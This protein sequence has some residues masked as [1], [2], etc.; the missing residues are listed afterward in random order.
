[1]TGFVY[2]EYKQN[3][4]LLISTAVI[5]FAVYAIP[6]FLMLGAAETEH[7][8]NNQILFTLAVFVGYIVL[9]LIQS[10]AFRGDDTKKWGY[11]IA[12]NPEGIKG[13][14]YTKYMMVLG[15]G[16]FFSFFMAVAGMVSGAIYESVYH[17]SVLAINSPYMILFLV[18]LIFVAIDI[19][20]IVRFGVK[21]GSIIKTTAII[22][23]VL[24]FTVVFVIS[25]GA[26][27]NTVDS[28]GKIFSGEN[29]GL[30]FTSIF[31]YLSF[32]FFYL[33]YKISCMIY[34]RGAENY[35]K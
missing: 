2:K 34:M 1:M 5:P 8:E 33:S 22:S 16:L 26:V 14:L 6:F 4:P 15:I 27:V 17:E 13:Y 31:P 21:M 29:S 19:P 20:F 30:I 10:L 28:I 23:F 25:P 35:T 9:A 18:Q 32:A 7:R 3:K 11:F 24:I 12:S